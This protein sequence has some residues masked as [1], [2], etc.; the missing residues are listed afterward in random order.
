MYVWGM[1]VCMCVCTVLYIYIHVCVTI[2]LISLVLFP[3]FHGS[4]FDHWPEEPKTIKNPSHTRVTCRPEPVP[5]PLKFGGHAQWLLEPASAESPKS[6]A[7]RCAGYIISKC[8]TRSTQQLVA[9]RC[10]FLQ[11]T[12]QQYS[13]IARWLPYKQMSYMWSRSDTICKAHG[14][15]TAPTA[16][17]KPKTQHLGCEMLRS[18]GQV[19][20]IL[21]LGDTPSQTST[22]QY[23][24]STLKSKL[25]HFKMDHFLLNLLRIV[26]LCELMRAAKR[27]RS[28]RH[29]NGET[30]H[31]APTRHCW[32]E[33]SALFIP[34][35]LTGQ[36]ISCVMK[37]NEDARPWSQTTCQHYNI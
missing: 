34:F 9:C 36:T 16:F 12:L 25:D 27:D 6:F 19:C 35:P 21:F 18:P 4:R 24:S 31:D 10:G 14:P 32:P 30:F 13:R 15:P 28:T 11:A 17:P 7:T 29:P 3:E 23:K 22:S 2:A 8:W 1:Y 5:A 20:S 26:S 33:G 37:P